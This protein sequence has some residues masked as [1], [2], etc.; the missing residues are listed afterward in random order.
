MQVSIK[1]YGRYS[2]DNYGAHAMQ[3]DIGRVRL[4]FSYQTIIAF[5]DDVS[6]LV[7]RENDWSSTTGKHLNAINSDKKRRISGAQFEKELAALLKLH[8]LTI[9]GN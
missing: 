3:V 1:P 7:I 8:D 9:P 6:G 4:Y 5:H 2:S